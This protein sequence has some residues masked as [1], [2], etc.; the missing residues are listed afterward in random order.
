[1]VRKGRPFPSK[2]QGCK[3]DGLASQTSSGLADCIAHY[4]IISSTDVPSDV[5]IID[6]RLTKTT[7]ELG[8]STTLTCS[9]SG[10]QPLQYQWK[11]NGT[12]L[13]VTSPTYTVSSANFSDAGRYTCKVSNW[14]GNSSATYT[15]SVQGN[16]ICYVYISVYGQ[17]MDRFNS[18]M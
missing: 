5:N 15:L 14:A 6:S 10:T 1:M 12:V 9:A 18:V 3:Q 4:Y 11:H 2:L 13:G 7:V 8:T 16:C 17:Y